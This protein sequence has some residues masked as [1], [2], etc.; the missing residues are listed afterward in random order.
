MA[1]YASLRGA[2]PPYGRKRAQNPLPL[3]LKILGALRLA[4]AGDRD[5]SFDVG[6]AAAEHV[7]HRG[8][9]RVERN[10]ERSERIAPLVR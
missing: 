9:V 7:A 8:I 10:S 4:L 3:E 5:E 1:E 6:A 2:I